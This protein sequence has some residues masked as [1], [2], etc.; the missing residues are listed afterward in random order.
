MPAI[1]NGTQAGGPYGVREALTLFALVTGN[2]SLLKVSTAGPESHAVAPSSDT[3]TTPT[4]PGAPAAAAAPSVPAP[5]VVANGGNGGVNGSGAGNGPAVSTPASGNG[6]FAFTGAD[7]LAL[8]MV[9][10]AL[11]L[12]GLTLTTAGRASSP[13]RSSGSSAG[14]DAEGRPPR[15]AAAERGS[16]VRASSGVGRRVAI[17]VLLVAIAVI[18]GLVLLLTG[19]DDNDDSGTATSAQ[20]VQLQDKFL[21]QTV[22]D[23]DKGISVRRPVELVAHEEPRSDHPEEPRPLSRHDALGAQTGRAG[24]ALRSELGRPLQALLQERPGA[25][26]PGAPVGG[27]PTTSDTIGFTDQ[28]SN[29]IRVLLSVGTGQKYAYL[30]EIVVENPRCQGDLQ[31]AQ[32]ALSS[33]QYTK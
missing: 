22:V 15:A 30:T 7:L 31:L 27:I 18:G 25:P 33:I 26:A 2:S 1:Q 11:I 6:S 14:G 17:G 12:G 9:G 29:P 32:V 24:E 16:S 8:G 3:N 19:G 20:T 28:K 21:N 4:P 10:G 23:V 13:D 5:R